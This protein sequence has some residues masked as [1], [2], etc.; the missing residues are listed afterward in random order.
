M[1]SLRKSGDSCGAKLTVVVENVPT[2]LGQPVFDR[3]DADLAY[4]IM[5]IN[6]VK[7]VEI[8]SGL[9]LLNNSDLNIV[10]KLDLLALLLIMLVAF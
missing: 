2:G 3:L 1:D 6:A 5:G 9:P 8:G 10:M 7:G 4:A